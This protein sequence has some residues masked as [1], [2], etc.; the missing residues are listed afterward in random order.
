MDKNRRSLGPELMERY[1]E[2]IGEGL[3]VPLGVTGSSMTPFLVHGRDIVQLSPVTHPLRRGDIVLYR[4]ENGAYILH[5][6]WRAEADGYTM[7]GDGQRVL[8][9]GIRR[10]QIIAV[11]TSC[12]RKGRTERPGTFWWDF[13]EKFWIRAVP[14][15]GVF[16]GIYGL[17]EKIKRRLA[18]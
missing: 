2:L 18:E 7:V 8:E 16:R 3:T 6:I 14:L 9:P 12:V 4:R 11:V 13:F 1:A 5:R 10:E 17:Y 15:R